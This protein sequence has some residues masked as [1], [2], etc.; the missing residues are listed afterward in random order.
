MTWGGRI[1]W[2][3]FL[4]LF[5]TKLFGGPCFMYKQSNQIRSKAL[6]WWSD[7][8]VK[9]CALG[10]DV[11]LVEN[12]ETFGCEYAFALPICSVGACGKDSRVA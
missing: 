7:I 2:K 11:F 6:W 3:E 8:A 12:L 1:I 5:A 10:F 4:Y 9:A